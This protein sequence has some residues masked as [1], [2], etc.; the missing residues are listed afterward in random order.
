ME[1]S[2]YGEVTEV[3]T[4]SAVLQMQR[5]VIK[6]SAKML[7]TVAITIAPLLNGKVDFSLKRVIQLEEQQLS[8]FCQ[9][10][11][12]LKHRTQFKGNSRANGFAKVMYVNINPDE[13]VNV[14]MAEK[15]ESSQQKQSITFEPAARYQL[16]TMA[17]SQLTLN[18][19]GYKQT[20][21]ET[22]SVLKASAF[23]AYR[24]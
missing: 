8:L 9:S 23:N 5:M 6:R 13:T 3:Y 19:I 14:I 12:G 17:V 2:P 16:L 15:A 7:H 4:T 18:S 11:M 24:K 20:M 10:L 21:S 1:Q 22:L